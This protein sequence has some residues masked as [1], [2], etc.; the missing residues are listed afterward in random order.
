MKSWLK[1]SGTTGRDARFG[2]AHRRWHRLPPGVALPPLMSAAALIFLLMFP[3]SGAIAQYTATNLVSNTSLYNPVNFDPNLIDGWGL[4]ALPDSPWWISAQ[5][6]VSSPLYDARG[7]VEHLLVDIPCVTDP[8]TGAT[9]VPCPIPPGA[10]FE[11][12]NPGAMSFLAGPT[13]SGPTGIVGNVFPKAFEENGG[14]A[15]F[16]FATLDGLIVAWNPANGTRAVV[17]ANRFLVPTP[18]PLGAPPGTTYQGL[19]IAGPAWDPHLYAT[20]LFGEVEGGVDVDV[21]DKNFKYVGSFAADSNIAS[22]PGVEQ[23]FGPY[24]IQAVGDK[25][26]VTYYPPFFPSGNGIVDVCDLSISA[27]SP[28]CRRIIDTTAEASP[29]VAAP[30]GIA[31]APDDFGPLSHKLLIGNVDDGLIHAFD[32]YNGTLIGTL[33]LKNGK[34]F[35]VPGYGVWRSVRALVPTAPSIPCSLPRDH[36]RHLATRQKTPISTA[37]ACLV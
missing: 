34:P 17:E 1:P 11:P 20:N 35:A 9:T 23:P 5:N 36:R 25:L 12:N 29:T 14:P 7:R 30:W 6:T 19:A 21:F 31:L 27:T 13:G 8:T 16:I 37:R 22:L 33:N 28:T 32:P 26:Y 2:I 4:A 24:G 18:Y 10:V 3:A 15:Q